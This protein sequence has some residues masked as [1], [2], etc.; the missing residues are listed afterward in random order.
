MRNLNFKN[1]ISN[2]I[3]S[4]AQATC[5]TCYHILFVCLFWLFTI[6][7][8]K[9]YSLK[10]F[11][12]LTQGPITDEHKIAA[13]MLSDSQL[14]LPCDLFGFAQTVEARTLQDDMSCLQAQLVT[15]HRF[16]HFSLEWVCSHQPTDVY[17]RKCNIHPDWNWNEFFFSIR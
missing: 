15:K 13:L 7:Q 12:K 5:I 17:Q 16:Q 4:R 1:Q 14:V 6:A 8:P 9:R 2:S 11:C 3:G 10:H